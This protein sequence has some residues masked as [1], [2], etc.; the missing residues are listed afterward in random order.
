MVASHRPSYPPLDGSL[1]LPE[2][3]EFNAQH[4]SDIAFFVYD[5]P[6][7]NDLVSISHL[8]FYQA[9]HRA[10]QKIRPGRTGTDNEVVVLLGNFDT[11]LFHTIFMGTI[12]A[13]LVVRD[14][15][16]QNDMTLIIATFKPFP[17]SP[18]NSAAAVLNMMEKTKCRRLITTYHSLGPLID[19]IKTDIATQGAEADNLQVDEALLLK[20]LYPALVRD[21]PDEAFVL[22]PPQTAR[23][24]KNDVLFYLHS[25]GSTGFPKPIPITNLTA[26]HWCSSRKR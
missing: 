13:G 20:D 16:P 2:L 11:L 4:N 18:R 26:I 5:E 3:V 24:S 9:C 14:I 21:T 1:F 17:T 10:A 25:S 15:I 23:S 7:S 22:Y 19:G 12:L 6:D 8:D